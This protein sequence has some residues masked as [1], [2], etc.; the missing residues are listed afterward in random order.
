MTS[1]NNTWVRRCD[2][3]L[4]RRVLVVCPGFQISKVGPDYD[5]AR[6]VAKI[7]E[8][9]GYRV[10][11]PEFPAPVFPATIFSVYISTLL[12]GGLKLWRKILA[13]KDGIVFVSFLPVVFSVALFKRVLG[14][15]VKVLGY[16]AG[17]PLDAP[18]PVRLLYWCMG[19]LTAR[20]C[21]GL[22]MFPDSVS[23]KW[24]ARYSRRWLEVGGV[25]V[26]V[27]RPPCTEYEKLE[28]RKARGLDGKVLVG[29]IGPFNTVNAA[30]LL[31]VLENLQRTRGDVVFVLIGDAAPAQRVRKQRLVF[32]GRVA[33]LVH[34]L[35]MLDCALIP[36]FSRTGSPMSKMIY[37][38]AAGLA[39][40]T[41]NPEGM[42]VRH[43]VE[44]LIGSLDELPGLV[45]S[46]AADVRLRR[47]LGLNARK[48]V[49]RLYDWSTN[50]G[51]L[52][53]FIEEVASS[54]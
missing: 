14:L 43:G 42:K 22:V 53:R 29:V 39:V 21:D 6:G 5:F 41:N 20:L 49:A 9:S 30:A 4:S 44:A 35:C 2:A 19:V 47:T 1:R 45:N 26:D 38:M 48:Y 34:T 27:S 24:F 16:M 31:Y 50:G 37:S 18:R 51:K 11:V 40:V 52:T 25:L 12:G 7:F 33:D 36:R 28:W 15:P 8:A 13:M 23:V 10:D 46:L 32:L 17:A 54:G 3:A